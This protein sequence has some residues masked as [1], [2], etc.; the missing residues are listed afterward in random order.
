MDQLE[1]S[2]GEKEKNTIKEVIDET[3]ALVTSYEK[4]GD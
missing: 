2:K 1:G 4:T 3:F